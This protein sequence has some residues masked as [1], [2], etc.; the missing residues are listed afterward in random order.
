M[1]IN[2]VAYSCVGPPINGAQLLLF[3]VFPGKNQSYL[4]SDVMN[5]PNTNTNEGFLSRRLGF[6]LKGGLMDHIRDPQW[7]IA[8]FLLV[9]NGSRPDVPLLNVPCMAVIGP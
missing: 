1:C 4:I 3:P 7:C 9:G 8:S 6:T 2:R 5:L